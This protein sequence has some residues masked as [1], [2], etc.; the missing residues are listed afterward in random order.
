VTAQQ[1][2]GGYQ[3][4]PNNHIYNVRIDALPTRSDSSTLIA[5]AGSV[6]LNYLP[7]FVANYVDASTPTQSMVFYYTPSNNGIYQIPAYPDIKI[8]SG[9]FNATQ[10]N[11]FNNDHHLITLDTTNG[12]IQEMYQFYPAG[13]ATSVEGCATCTSQS[14]QKYSASSY[15]QPSNGT[16]DAAGLDLLPLTLRL[17]EFEHAIATGGT[18]NHALR[19]TLQNSYLHNAFL[20]PAVT[21]ANAGN[22]ANYYGERIRLKSS[23]NISGFSAAAQ[24]LLTQ[25]KQYGLI[26]ADGGYGW[27]VTVEG[28]RW[29]KALANVFAEIQNAN[30]AP[31]NFEVVDESSLMI[32]SS[33]GEANINRE[34]VTYSSSTGTVNTDVVL[35]GVAITLPNDVMYI[36]AGSPVQTFSAFVNIGSVTWSMSPTLGTLTSDG[37]YTPPA[38]SATVQN[39]TVTATSTVNSAV[40]AQMNLVIYPNGTIRLAPGHMTFPG[41]G[42]PA[43]YVDS[44][45]NTWFAGELA[46]GDAIGSFPSGSAFGYANGGSWPFTTDIALYQTPIYSSS[47]DLRFNIIVPNGTYQIVAKFANNSGSNTSQGNFII[48]TQGS[49]GSPVDIFSL[50]GNNQPYDYTASAT[51]T[52]G[53]LS[54]VLRNVNTTGNGVAP[55]ISALQIVQT[56]P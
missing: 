9:Y 53:V 11:P 3:L 1:S 27:Q 45:G 37:V 40:S 14:G 16:T 50:V 39:T 30:I 13:T 26:I 6:P 55:F 46:G 54:F 17:Q 19:M 32:S 36:Q 28:T 56:A 43:N 29:P 38:T 7:G 48:E 44:L 4:L 34:T 52:N 8:E 23:F 35:Q 22:G 12:T 25:L 31:S 18:I 33:S 41:S 21:S 15:A 47:N 42:V 2:A 5:G 20:W 49:A 10:Y 24:I 51:V